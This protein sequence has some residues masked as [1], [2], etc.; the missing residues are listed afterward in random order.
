MSEAGPSNLVEPQNVGAPSQL[1]ADSS[2]STVGSTPASTL[3]SLLTDTFG[4]KYATYLVSCALTAEE[5]LLSSV[6][7]TSMQVSG[8]WRDKILLGYTLLSGADAL[9]ILCRAWE[10]A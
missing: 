9:F 5:M 3:K 2:T 10:L 4:D 6:V 7:L 8:L 1:P